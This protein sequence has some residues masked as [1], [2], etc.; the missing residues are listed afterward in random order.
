ME[1]KQPKVNSKQYKT[2]KLY[3]VSGVGDLTFTGL[4]FSWFFDNQK[5]GSRTGVTIT[6]FTKL[7]QSYCT[8]SGVRNTILK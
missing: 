8:S 5:T 2:Q 4:V 1:I 3:M 7:W 6:C